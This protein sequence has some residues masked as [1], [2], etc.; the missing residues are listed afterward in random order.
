VHTTTRLAALTL[1]LAACPADGGTKVCECIPDDSQQ[2]TDADEDWDEPSSPTCGEDL[3]ATVEATSDDDS[4]DSTLIMISNPEALDCALMALRDRK[5][6]LVRWSWSDSIGQ[7]SD[8]GYILVRI[9]GTAVHRRWG[10]EDLSWVADDA[11]AG[12]LPSAQYYDDCL[13]NTDAGARFDCLRNVELAEPTVC[14]AGW[15]ISSI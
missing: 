13:A 7:F 10:E 2:D 12:E 6:G 9:D 14:D 3:C 4:E 15:T 8:T 5:P 1:L 11:R